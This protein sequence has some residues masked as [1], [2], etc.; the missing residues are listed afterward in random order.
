MEIDAEVETEEGLTLDKFT[1]FFRETLNQPA[2]RSQADKEMDY[3]ASNQLDSE[4]LQKMAERGLPPAVENTIAGA[5]DS[6]L[7]AE[8]K[9]RT[10]W[11][12][13]PD[14]DKSGQDVA[15]AFSYKL[16]Q[17]ER[18]SRADRSCSDAYETQVCI[19]L[20]WVE[21]AKEPDPFKYPYRCKA[22]HRN[23]IW[24]DWDATDAMLDDARYLIR[25]KWVNKDVAK[26]MFPDSEDIIEH[27][28]SGWAGCDT[29]AL[30]GGKSTGLAM[31]ADIERGWSIE[32]QHWRDIEH[33]KIRLFECWYR[34]W[35]NQLILKMPDGRVVEFD[36]DDPLHIQAITLG[37]IRPEY[38]MISKVSRAMFA[39]PHKLSD[40]E[41][42]YRH[43]HFPYIPF[44]GNR[45]DR[46]NVP[47]G[48]IRHMM[49]MQDNINATISKIRWG[50]SA[51]VTRRTDG[52][53]LGDD[54][55]FR[56]EIARPDADIILDAAHMSQ[57]GAMFEIDRNF[58]LNEQQYKMLT[59]ARESIR[60]IGGISEEF[61]GVSA[62]QSQS[63]VAY[64]AK[65]EQGQQSLANIDDNFRES[66]AQ[67]G[68]LL[69]SMIIQDS[70]G[71]QE[72]VV[73]DGH[74]IKDDKHI[75]LNQPVMDDDGI[76]YLNNDIERTMLK[77]VLEEVPSTPSFRTQQLSAL[78][79]AYKA[80]PPEYQRIML[81][82][83]LNLTDVP[84][85]E[86]I[87]TA[88]KEAD[89]S[90]S[91]EMMEQQNKVKELE[92]KQLMTDA[93]IMKLQAETGKVDA[94][95]TESALRGI[96]SAMQSAGMVV[97][98]PGITPVADSIYL[99]AGG[100][101]DN[102]LPLAVEAQLAQGQQ[103]Q[104][105]PVDQN[106]S[107]GFPATGN[108]S[109]QQQPVAPEQPMPMSPGLG[110][111]AGIETMQNEQ[112]LQ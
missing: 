61:Q 26:I 73:I 5:I 41:S 33:N 1:G 11:R 91:K 81:P 52:A 22:V 3:L 103:P 16:S 64:N 7:G 77:V 12:V 24:W 58:E 25:A 20:G 68:D 66:R 84:N 71:I 107:P 101:D 46:T 55:H 9:S 69:L 109:S 4:I 27:S 10:D 95:K 112:S 108:V 31:A 90:P 43:N 97:T 86:E 110:N 53:V 18:K 98:N 38:A 63:G 82:H 94:E 80:A 59:D 37:N 78:S 102:E 87:L 45:E 34:E 29:F 92:L 39:G 14:G 47:Y 79:E 65:V 35:E 44:W 70:I 93:Q 83:L 85:K 28:I 67:V 75:M 54:E 21:V 76:E 111:N 104:P 105:Q 42:P 56:Q 89:T 19:G 13:I 2:W 100:K 99:S 74:A 57:P 23:E 8:A 48:R 49:Y 15:D 96:F 40:E 50:L 36:M 51:T 60:K 30:D 88:I 72:E 32:E 62:N 106:T 6:I 17:A